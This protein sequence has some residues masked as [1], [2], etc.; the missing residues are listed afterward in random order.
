MSESQGN[1][2][3]EN[4][5]IENFDYE[6]N[7]DDTSFNLPSLDTTLSIF[8]VTD[9]GFTSEDSIISIESEDETPLPAIKCWEE[10][11]TL[12]FNEAWEYAIYLDEN[13][14]D[15]PRVFFKLVNDQLAYIQKL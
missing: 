3:D 14:I 4:A 9:S 12:T 13:I 7:S 6:P 10:V 15:I 2:I 5:I 1:S 11:L 8:T